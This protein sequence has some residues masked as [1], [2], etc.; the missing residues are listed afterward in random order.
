M[1]TKMACLHFYLNLNKTENIIC[2]YLY[3]NT[4]SYSST[5]ANPEQDVLGRENGLLGR[6]FPMHCTSFVMVIAPGVLEVTEKLQLC[7]T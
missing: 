5:P 7:I 6:Y 3:R 1:R 4:V 2:T